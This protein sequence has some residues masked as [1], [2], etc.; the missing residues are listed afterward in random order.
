MDREMLCRI[1]TE[2]KDFALFHHDLIESDEE[3]NDDYFI[4]M[5]LC[6]P[7]EVTSYLELYYDE[8]K[9]ARRLLK[10]IESCQ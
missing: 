10:E 1:A 7:E 8:E 3:N 5:L 2:V 6:D 9:E 4:Q